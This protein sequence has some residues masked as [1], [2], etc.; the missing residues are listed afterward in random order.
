M[1][2]KRSGARKKTDTA[3]AAASMVAAWCPPGLA[4]DISRNMRYDTTED[5]RNYI[6][7]NMPSTGQA[8]AAAKYKSYRLGFSPRAIRILKT[9]YLVRRDGTMETL[10]EM[11]GRV[12]VCMAMPRLGGAAPPRHI[13]GHDVNPHHMIQY[14][15]AAKQAGGIRQFEDAVKSYYRMMAARRF[16]PNSPA[17]MNAGGPLGQ[18]PACFVLDM[19]DTLTSIMDAVKDT[20]TIFRSGGGVAINYSKLRPAGTAVGNTAGTV[21]GPVS[22]MNLVDCVGDTIKQGGRR[23]AANMGVLDASHPDILDFVRSKEDGTKLN[24]SNV[25]VGLDA[26]FWECMDA[27]RPYHAMDASHILDCVAGSAHRT[28]ESGVIFFDHI[29]RY[30][31]LERARGGPPRAT[32][33]CWAGD[34]RILTRDGPV[35]FRDLA[36]GPSKVMVMTRENDGTISYRTMEN[37][38]VTKQ[39]AEAVCLVVESEQTGECAALRCTPDHTVYV[40]TAGGVEKCAASDLTPGMSLA[41][42]YEDGSV[43]EQTVGVSC[44]V[45]EVPVHTMQGTGHPAPGILPISLAARK[46]KPKKKQGTTEG[47]ITSDGEIPGE[48]ERKRTGILSRFLNH[49]VLAVIRVDRTDVYNGMVDT[50]HNYFVECGDGHYIMSGN[51][52]EQALY[53]GESCNL[54]SINLAEYV[55][56]YTILWDDLE[57]DIRT[58]TRMLDGAVDRTRHPAI[59]MER[60]GNETR[61]IGLGV[62]GVADMLMYMGIPYN[63]GAAYKLFGRLAEFLSYHS[64]AESAEMAAENGPFPLF[65]RSA[66]VEGRLPFAGDTVPYNTWEHRGRM[67]WDDLVRKIQQHGIRNVLTTTIAPTGTISMLAGCSSGIEPVYSLAYTKTVSVG[68]F[69]YGCP[70]LEERHPG[71]IPAVAA[72]GGVIPDGMIDDDTVYVTA[73]QIHWADHILAQAAWQRWIGNSI[74]KTVNMPRTAAVRDVRDAYVLAHM[75]GCRGITVY[76]DGSRDTRVPEDGCSYGEPVP[77]DAAAGCL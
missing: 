10:A 38:G 26:E 68:E 64:M 58:C 32:S 27:G 36:S 52:G 75:V 23:R 41:S 51:C 17:I 55:R 46:G 76:R 72:A 24:N 61:R 42:L 18:L 9:R 62:M 21:S 3:K 54:G 69:H 16:L 1:V 59:P 50:T 31:M 28:A 49:T 43:W 12:A 53:P 40:A 66:Y 29:N 73:R 77:S 56:D 5:V 44:P 15:V 67:P 60:A 45:N 7:A 33:P 25:S 37:P 11:L 13:C 74:S 8:D 57:R 65:D 6:M 48:P 34:T 22:F 19:E 2:V 20:A 70:V 30:S 71:I 39:T 35:S 4:R 14:A 63:S 47:L